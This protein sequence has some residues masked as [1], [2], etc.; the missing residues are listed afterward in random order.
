MGGI[1]FVVFVVYG[2]DIH[3][4]LILHK[5]EKLNYHKTKKIHE[6]QKPWKSKQMKIGN[7]AIKFSYVHQP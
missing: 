7:S 2:H 3:Q 5:H 4:F 1:S 6:F